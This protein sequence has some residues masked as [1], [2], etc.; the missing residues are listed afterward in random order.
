MPTLP[1]DPDAALTA[2][3]SAAT[4]ITEAGAA[5]RRVAETLGFPLFQ[6][7]FRVPVS[8]ARPCQV[9]LSGY[10]R[11]WRQRY[12]DRGYL[13][14]DPVVR[15]ALGS[16]VPFAW[17]ELALDAPDGRGIFEEAADFGL[18]HGFDGPV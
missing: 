1:M 11:A 5:C 12:D 4:D 17:D 16:V 15:R 8:F 2:Q 10:P 13:S 7:G 9:I 18:R 3:I 6:Y 14:V